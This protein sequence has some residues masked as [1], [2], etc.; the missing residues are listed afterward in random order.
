MRLRNADGG[1]GPR[2]G[3]DSNAVASYY[4]LD[5]LRALKAIDAV[6]ERATRP[7][8]AR[9][10]LSSNL[11]VFT[12]QIEAHGKG[13]PAEAVDLAR[14]LKI[15]LWGAKNAS[16]AWLE[17]ASAIAHAQQVP[18]T[19]FTSNEEYGTWVSVPGMGTYSHTSDIIAPAGA[20]I[21]DSLAGGQDVTWEE[22]RERRLEP[23]QAGDG[24]LVWQFG[25][26]EALTRLFLDDSLTRGGFA[27][28][29]SFHFGN[30]DFTNS[31]PFLKQYRNQIPYVG[32]QDA[33]GDES[34]WWGDQLEGFRTLFL[35]TEP[36]WDAW[37]D[38]LQNNRVAAVRR[39]R[40]SGGEMWVH[41]P[42]DV[43]EIAMQQKD[44]WQWWDN[45]H[46]ERPKVSIVALTPRSQFEVARPE[47]GVA[48][49]VRLQW[50]NTTQGKPK[51]P[52][53][54]LVRLLLDG[55]EVATE[56]VSPGPKG[57]PLD[58]YYIY[59]IAELTP[60]EHVAAAVVKDIGTREESQ[61]EI[62]FGTT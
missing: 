62:R 59:N 27:A 33:H 57:R 1:F 20:N 35:A 21:G 32:L 30:P 51:T 58:D 8:K 6:E 3:W 9:R 31:E 25:E 54:E 37:L 17:A 39:D 13:S 45:P 2:E 53:T 7:P 23:L 28:I 26:N 61:R 41:G 49:R 18:V 55:M 5:A 24:R 44:R 46:V 38:A 10:P 52:R 40:V 22:F 4:A 43:L 14:A 15:D 19:F 29:S 36:T 60:G 42:P 56:H 16:P 48:I 12:I 34:W 11:K 47:T 50:E